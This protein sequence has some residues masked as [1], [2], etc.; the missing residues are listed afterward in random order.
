MICYNMS[1]LGLLFS[2]TNLNEQIQSC[3]FY[4]GNGI[5]NICMPIQ[6]KSHL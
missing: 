2:V 1:Q 5:F 3:L 6:N 4:Y